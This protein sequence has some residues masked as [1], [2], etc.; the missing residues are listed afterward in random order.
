MNI[1]TS[2]PK[3]TRSLTTTLALAFF[4]VSAFALLLSSGVQ[5]ALHIRTQQAALASKQQFIAE[6][7][8]KTVSDF[9]E[10]KFSSLETAVEFANPITATAESQKAF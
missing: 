4:G 2:T 9:I 1:E 5:I 7:A 3:R 8:G 6:N 10:E